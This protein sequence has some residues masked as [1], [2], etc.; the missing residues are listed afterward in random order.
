MIRVCL[1][2]SPSGWNCG[3][4]SQ[5][6]IA[7]SSGRTARINPLA[8]SKS[9]PRARLGDRKIRTNSSRIRSALISLIDG[10]VRAQRLPGRRLD[11]EIRGRSRNEPR[12]A[13]AIDPPRNAA[14][15]RRSRESSRA[16]RSARPPTKSITSLRR[17]IEEHPVDREVAPRRV[18][19]RGREM[20][21][22]RSATIEISAI[23]AEGRDLELKS[24][25]EDHDHAEMRADRVGAR[26]RFSAPPPVARRSRCRCLSAPRRARD[27]AHNRPRSRPRA[28]ASRSRRAPSRGP[29]QAIFRLV[30][31][32]A[33]RS[34]S[35]VDRLNVKMSNELM[36]RKR[37]VAK[38]A[39]SRETQTFTRLAA[40]LCPD[41]DR[42]A[43]LARVAKP[44]GALRLFRHRHHPRGRLDRARDRSA[45]GARR[46]RAW[47]DCSTPPS[48]TRPN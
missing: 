4:C 2:T 40:H 1:K 23:R 8:S 13:S 36:Y 19:F 39:L 24:I 14:P 30:G 43:L 27:R 41:R 33:H 16:S 28:R 26:E 29:P 7:S 25:F 34:R 46:R 15:D 9:Q 31:D 45:G 48:A 3:G 6:F 18:F 35:A 21:L 10:G 32:V 38:L 17:R 47:A 12:A 20:H 22:G 37:T 5:P 44:D 42:P 11:L